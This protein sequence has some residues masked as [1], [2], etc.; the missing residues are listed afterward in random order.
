MSD[1]P[2]TCPNALRGMNHRGLDLPAASQTTLLVLT[3]F[4]SVYKPNVKRTDLSLKLAADPVSD[5][6]SQCTEGHFQACASST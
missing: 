5:A 4:F 2:E 6:L 1:Q 3:K